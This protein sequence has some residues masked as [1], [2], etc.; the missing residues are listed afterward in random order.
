M[1]IRIPETNFADKILK[2]LGKRRGVK[3]PS[4][5]YEKFG[6]YVSAKARKENFFKAFFRTKH[7]KLPEDMIDLYSLNTTQPDPAND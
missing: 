3:F 1:T 2:F 5:A 7:K 6:H 4:E